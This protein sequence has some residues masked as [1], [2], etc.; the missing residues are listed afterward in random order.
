MADDYR[1]LQQ[2]I[3]DSAEAA[4]GNIEQSKTKIRRVRD[5]SRQATENVREQEDQ[6]HR[7]KMFVQSLPEQATPGEEQAALDSLIFLDQAMQKTYGDTERQMRHLEVS[8]DMLAQVASTT[9]VTIG[10][11][12]VSDAAVMN[13]VGA[14]DVNRT[15]VEKASAEYLSPT[16]R[17]KRETLI[18]RLGTLTATMEAKA[19]EAWQSFDDGEYMSAAHATREVLSELGHLLGP[20]KDVE[21]AAWYGPEKDQ[22]RPSQR[23]RIKYAII[24]AQKD[25]RIDAS[26]LQRVESLATDARDSYTRL[27]TEAHRREKTWQRERVREYMGTAEAVIRQVLDLRDLLRSK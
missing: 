5:I 24:G 27:T 23:Q 15:P 8:K 7:V 16:V 25:S 19:R 14:F 9:A 13:I 2:S 1:R 17:E 22:G 26:D 6:V 21:K 18:Q 10:A 12:S 3:V 11:T 20:N 4:E